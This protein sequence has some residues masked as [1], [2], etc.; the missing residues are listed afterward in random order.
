MIA[1]LTNYSQLAYFFGSYKETLKSSSSY[2]NGGLG[3]SIELNT[4]PHPTL[5]SEGKVSH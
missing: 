2:G 3:I 4:E 5:Q 1:Q